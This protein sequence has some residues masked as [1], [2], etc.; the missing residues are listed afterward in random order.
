MHQNQPQELLRAIDLSAP[1][2]HG[3]MLSSAL[4]KVIR[5]QS[6]DDRPVIFDQ[7]S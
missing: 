6:T 5:K 4:L 2:P 3:S 7:A 1:A